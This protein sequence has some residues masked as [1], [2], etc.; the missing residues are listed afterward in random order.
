MKSCA[1]NIL[2]QVCKKTFED[3]ARLHKHLKS[4]KLLIAE[5]YQTYFPRYDKLDRSLI[6]FRNKEQ[7]LTTDFN[8]RRNLRIWLERED[9]NIVR[10]YCRNLLECRKAKKALKWTPTQV[11]LRTTMLPPVQWYH[12]LFGNYY[13]LCEEL[14]LSNK[15]QYDSIL[16]IPDDK[17]EYTIYVDTREQKPL[18]FVSHQTAVQTLKIGDYVSSNQPPTCQVCIER[19]AMNDFVGT[20]SGGYER[21]CRELDKAV[22][23]NSYVVVLVESTLNQCMDSGANIYRRFTK[24]TPDYVFHNVRETIQKYP[25]V[26]FLFVDGREVA[27][28]IIEKIFDSHC[29]YRHVDLQLLYDIHKL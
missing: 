3:E 14:G 18:T 16:V 7:Y 11:E 6:L 26:Q 8:S 5:Y 12:K 22:A 21:F 23:A 20:L 28:T 27:A 13:A 4:H 1:D 29:N 9:V 15:F 10:A 25:M 2:C 17:P 19:K 24:V